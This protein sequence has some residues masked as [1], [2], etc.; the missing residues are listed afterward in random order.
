LITNKRTSARLQDL[1]DVEQLKQTE[2]RR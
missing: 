2:D 1:A